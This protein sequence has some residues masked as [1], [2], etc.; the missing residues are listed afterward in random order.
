MEDSSLT[1]RPQAVNVL[2]DLIFELSMGV[3][4]SGF[5]GL[6]GKEVRGNIRPS[7][8]AGTCMLATREREGYWRVRQIYVIKNNVKTGEWQQSKWPICNKSSFASLRSIVREAG[9][10]QV[11]GTYVHCLF[12]ST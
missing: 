3:S 7:N 4:S 5:P 6:V 12:P 1:V 2:K 10:L 8:R 9:R 11:M